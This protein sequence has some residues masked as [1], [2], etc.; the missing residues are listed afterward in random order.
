MIYCNNAATTFPKPQVVKDIVTGWFDR[1]PC[2][3]GR[4]GAEGADL[5]GE[6][7]RSIAG[8]FHISDPTNLFF[9]SGATESLNLLVQ[10]LDL[11]HGHVVTTAIEHNS[12]LR[13]LF[14][15]K[16]LHRIDLEIVPCDQTGY[17]EPQNIVRALTPSTKAIFL[18]H[19]S[20]V[21]GAV[22]DIAEICR[23]CNDRNIICAIDASQSAGHLPISIDEIKPSAMV[24][25]GHKGLF[26]LPGSG[27]V[28]IAPNLSLRPLLTGGTGVRSD[29]LSQP[30]DRPLIYESGTPNQP[31]ILSLTAGIGYIQSLG[32]EKI[33]ATVSDF[34]KRFLDRLAN[35]PRIK[36][37]APSGLS[38]CVAITSLTIDGI[39]PGEVGYLLE[40]A[41][42]IVVRT[43][44]HCAPLIHHHLDTDKGTVRVSFSALSRNRDVDAVADA[45]LKIADSANMRNG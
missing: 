30:P 11:S 21:T 40:S 38:S 28:Y 18:S 2:E 20:N 1:V 45:I 36:A 24:C 34:R 17:V 37:I 29:L 35:H 3:A 23:I 13:P 43:G 7:R 42:G 44:L 25:A 22:Q 39:S 9:S 31:G 33:Q 14:R 5:I 19:A 15:L 27:I 4:T 10:G 26:G 41:F 8:F 16:N 12:L 32:W 6:A